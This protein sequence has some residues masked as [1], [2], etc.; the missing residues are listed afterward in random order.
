MERSLA[1][2][3]VGGRKKCRRTGV[4][5]GE[6]QVLFGVIRDKGSDFGDI[7]VST[8]YRS[9]LWYTEGTEAVQFGWEEEG[10]NEREK[11]RGVWRGVKG[12]SFVRFLSGLAIVASSEDVVESV[13]YVQKTRLAKNVTRSTR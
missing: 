8:R 11:F 9:K 1:G 4:G 7:F 3:E 10:G 6:C 2:R 5:R 13:K 12:L